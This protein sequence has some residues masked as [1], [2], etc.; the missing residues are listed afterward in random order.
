MIGTERKR[1]S[2]LKAITWRIV[3][4]VT[5]MVL[6][7]VFSG[8][9]TL[10]LSVGILETISKMLLYYFHERAWGSVSWGILQ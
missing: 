9:M 4:S 1:R 2:I 10:A 7:W 6:V 8:N 5:T 3:A